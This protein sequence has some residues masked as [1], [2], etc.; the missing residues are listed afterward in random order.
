MRLAVAVTLGL[1]YFF[2]FGWAP[3]PWSWQGIDAYHELAKSLA[4]GEPFHTTDVPWGY[5]YFAAACYRLFGERIWVPLVIQATLNGLVP[6]LLYRLVAPLA[7]R[8]VAA[9]AALIAGVFSF[10]T[11]YASTQSSDSICTVLFLGGLLYFARAARDARLLPIVLSGV[12][13]GL[14][15]QFRPN[16]VLFPGCLIVGYWLIR[17]RSLRT[18]AHTVVF[19]AVVLALQMPWIVRNYR[20]TGMFLPTSTHGGVQLWYGTLQVGPFLESR[21]HNPRFYF[22]SPAFTYTS[23]WQRPLEIRSLYRSCVN[24]Q[25]MPTDLIYWTDRDAEHRRV[26]P[27]P[28]WNEDRIARFTVPAQPNHTALY[29]YFEQGS[30]LSPLEGPRNPNVAFVSDDHL[31]DLDRHDD[32]LD[33]FD[34]IRVLRH[35]AWQEPVRAADK[36]DFNHDGRLDDA[37]A[38]A[39]VARMVPDLLSR[40]ATPQSATVE[41]ATEKVTLHLVDGSWIAVPRQFGGRQTDVDVSLNGEMAPA[42]LSRHRTFS[43]MDVSVPRGQCFSA[44]EV[45]FNEPYYL[46]EPNA[47]R[48][49]MALAMDNIRR[50]P[51]AFVEASLY[52]AVRLFVVRGTDDLSTA[53]QFRWS[54]IV[55]GIGTALSLGYLA[56]FAAGGI[57]AYRRRS[58]LL[59]FLV[60]IVYVPATICLVLT[61][62]RYTVT[63]QPLMFAFVAVA[64]AAALRLDETNPG[65]SS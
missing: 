9:L 46:S 10:N 40:T 51:G 58:R 60:P 26:D 39:I 49:Y 44:E 43:S 25:P 14:V 17:P 15:P 16:M 33:L 29:Y 50:S 38:A 63:V 13:F 55:Y 22:E 32:V 7:G 21:A 59:L 4:R 30:F 53:Q 5:A 24:G 57:I 11:I 12:L 42:L 27:A 65:S 45:S 28:G 8:R 23:L 20:L 35:V 18:L 61:N 41:V 36:L 2:I 54:H 64:L 1:G 3:H 62:M 37:D 19:A 52:R 31:G 6:L 56:I 47:M 34:L 48:R